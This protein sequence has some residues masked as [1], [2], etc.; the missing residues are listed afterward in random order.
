MRLNLLVIKTDNPEL[1]KAQ[2]EAIGFHFV[3]HRHGNGPLHYS[4]EVDG[5]VFEIYPLPKS[6]VEADSTTRLGFDVNDLDKV[7]VALE[8]ANWRMVS[9][10]KLTDWGY[11]AVVEDLD[12]RRVE[13][14]EFK[15]E[16]K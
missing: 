14:K 2:Y 12:G 8:R 7:V 13:L 16:Q 9:A 10:P 1:L 6:V 11:V 3:H 4:S 15:N 5:L